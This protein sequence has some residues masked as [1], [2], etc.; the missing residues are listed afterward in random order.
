MTD[1]ELWVNCILFIKRV[2]ISTGRLIDWRSKEE[3]ERR[4]RTARERPCCDRSRP[5]RRTRW[6]SNFISLCIYVKDGTWRAVD[7][8]PIQVQGRAAWAT[9]SASLSQLTTAERLVH[10]SFQQNATVMPPKAKPETQLIPVGK[11]EVFSKTNPARQ[12]G[13]RDEQGQ[14][15]TTSKALI[16]RN[17]KYGSQG[18]GELM[19]MGKMSGREKLD[20][21]AGM[22]Y[23]AV[24]HF[25]RSTCI[26]CS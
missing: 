5:K 20:L 1:R 25:C 8:L 14:R 23:P 9:S 2:E 19:H 24:P 17:G 22:H 13:K 16:L 15:P 6:S 12:H 4:K 18:T 21:L 11:K 10:R 26:D 3:V 7:Y